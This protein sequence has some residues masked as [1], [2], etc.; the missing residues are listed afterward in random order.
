MGEKF[1][2]RVDVRNKFGEEG[3]KIMCGKCGHFIAR[4]FASSDFSQKCNYCKS[5]N[6]AKVV[7]PKIGGDQKVMKRF[8]SGFYK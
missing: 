2:G 7:M 4:V 8:G 6:F 3:V 5:E 1:Q